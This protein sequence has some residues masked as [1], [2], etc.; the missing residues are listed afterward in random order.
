VSGRLERIPK[1]S[2][3]L[4]FRRHR[5]V[6]GAERL[7]LSGR[8]KL[9]QQHRGGQL[10]FGERVKIG[11]HVTFYLD[12]PEARIEIGSYSGI[13]RRTEICSKAS[14]H[15]GERCAIGWDVCITDTDYHE[16]EGIRSSKPVHIGDDVWIGSRAMILKGVTIGDGAVIGAGAVVA[17]DVPAR[18]LL[19]GAQSKLIRENV[20]WKI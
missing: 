10:V 8:I 3:G 20:S 19:A 15:I 6:V 12:S 7:M 2:R 18:A 11:Q 13:N 16:F 4:L 1:L 17:K 14:V 9:S 5:A